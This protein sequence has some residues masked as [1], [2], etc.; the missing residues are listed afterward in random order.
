MSYLQ[1]EG[2]DHMDVGGR[3]MSGTIIETREHGR[4]YG[5]NW[6]K[7]Y[8]TSFPAKAEQLPR[9]SEGSPSDGPSTNCILPETLK[10]LPNICFSPILSV[11]VQHVV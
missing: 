4:L 10:S 9:I 7:M 3:I 6:L 2:N 5:Y 8:G 11:L 1:D